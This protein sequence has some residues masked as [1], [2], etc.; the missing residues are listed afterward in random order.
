M[1]NITTNHA[2]TYTQWFLFLQSYFNFFFT[3]PTS[4][5][6]QF[7]IILNFPPN[8]YSLKQWKNRPKILIYWNNDSYPVG[9]FFDWMKSWQDL[10]RTGW[11]KRKAFEQTYGLFLWPQAFGATISR[12]VWEYK[13][14][15]WLLDGRQGN[16]KCM[17]TVIQP[18]D[19][20][21][22]FAKSVSVP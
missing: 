3:T 18:N 16:H 15:L 5:I 20:T 9:P 4:K 14:Q 19:P 8:F 2:I 13:C 12:I 11:N 22:R 10:N 21:H 7:Y 6:F 1:P 17:W